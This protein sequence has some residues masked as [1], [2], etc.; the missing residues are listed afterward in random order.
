MLS[1]VLTSDGEEGFIVSTIDKVGD[2]LA[3]KDATWSGEDGSFTLSV[4][5]GHWIMATM[6]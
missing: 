5:Y 6:A 1:V 2:I 3:L 4:D